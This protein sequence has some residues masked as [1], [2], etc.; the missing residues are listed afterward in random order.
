MLGAGVD[1]KGSAAQGSSFR[2]ENNWNEPSGMAQ[3]GAGSVS[4]RLRS[5]ALGLKKRGGSER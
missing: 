2:N 5:R 1:K 4:A 3:L